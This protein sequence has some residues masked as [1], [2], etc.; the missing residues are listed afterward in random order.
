SEYSYRLRQRDGRP[1]WIHDFTF[2]PPAGLV[3]DLKT[4]NGLCQEAFANVIA[5]NAE[6]DA[7]NRLVLGAGLTWREVALL[8][9]YGRY[10]KQIRIGFDLGYIA[11]TLNNHTAIAVELVRLFKTR[12][13]LARKLSAPALEE[14]QGRLV[15]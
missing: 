5:G 1:Y 9:A 2:A 12:F 15:E 7:F 10:L 3:V 13:Y 8:R 6:N 11:A 14:K 4:L